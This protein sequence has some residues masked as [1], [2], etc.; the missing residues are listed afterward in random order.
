M[1]PLPRR[2][3]SMSFDYDNHPPYCLRS[4]KPQAVTAF[5]RVCTGPD[6]IGVVPV[7]T[8]T[9]SR[10]APP[11]EIFGMEGPANDTVLGANRPIATLAG[12]VPRV[13]SLRTLAS[14][15]TN[16]NNFG[17]SSRML[18]I[19]PA[20]LIFHGCQYYNPRRRH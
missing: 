20:Q 15:K 1:A 16:L 12:T 9:S 7:A 18:M 3:L 11:G 8:G 10:M 4:Y 19:S 17:I 14:F 6:I 2:H 5:E 13:L